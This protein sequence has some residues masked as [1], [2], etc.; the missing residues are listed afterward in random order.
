MRIENDNVLNEIFEEEFE[1]IPFLFRFSKKRL[2][3]TLSVMGALLISTI[4]LIVLFYRSGT[5]EMSSTLPEFL[6]QKS[7]KVYDTG[8]GIG[9]VI[10]GT[11]L[12][13][14]VL[15][16][17]AGKLFEERAFK[18]AA[19]LANKI[20]IAEREAENRRWMQG[21]SESRF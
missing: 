1:K 2:I 3:I 21:R 5:Y 12:V 15:M 10:S 20:S 4:V 11:A 8:L 7:I 6:Y 18:K 14:T 19:V 16:I 13:L 17:V 9:L